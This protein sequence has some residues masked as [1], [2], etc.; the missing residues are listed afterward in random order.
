MKS[1]VKTLL[2]LSF[3]AYSGF[4]F[5]QEGEGVAEV[6]AQPVGAEQSIG[7]YPVVVPAG[8]QPQEGSKPGVKFRDVSFAVS[9]IKQVIES[10][11]KADF[12]AGNAISKDVIWQVHERIKGA[13]VLI[14]HIITSDKLSSDK[15][16]EYLAML[17]PELGELIFYVLRHHGEDKLKNIQNVSQAKYM[18]NEFLLDTTNFVSFRKSVLNETVWGPMDSATRDEL[19][20]LTADALSAIVSGALANMS[21]DD[22]LR[23]KAS[24]FWVGSI[25]DKALMI[26]GARL[27]AQRLTALVYLGSA[28]W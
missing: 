24:N 27:N 17:M 11:D 26:R 1:L 2:V 14:N 5:S 7:Q 21:E 8:P 3:V 12:A 25:L 23:D 9:N 18:L 16:S 4:S 13:V 22:P 19:S 28:F 20:E 15:R 6:A 10:L